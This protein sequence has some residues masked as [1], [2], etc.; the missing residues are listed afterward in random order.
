M[1]KKD[2]KENQELLKKYVEIYASS[3]S[4]KNDELEIVFGTKYGGISRINFENVI[5]RLKS[6]G[7][8]SNNGSGNYHL[9]IKNQ[10]INE[11]SGKTTMSSVRTTISGLTGIQKY[12]NTDE[13]DK[14]F[15]NTTF[16]QKTIKIYDEERLFPINYDD[17]GFR[18]NYKTEKTLKTEFGIVKDM[19]N[20]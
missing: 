18:V 14:D 20:K 1:N 2:S 8:T 13:I 19:L 11:R 10:F 9:N 12:C 7:F 5:S 6:L 3:N 17:F 4:I 16:M 15:K